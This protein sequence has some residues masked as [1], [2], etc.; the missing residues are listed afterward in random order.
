MAAYTE[1]PIIFALSNPRAQPDANPAGLIAWADGRVLIASCSPFPPA[2]LSGVTYVV[3]QVNNDKLYSG[4][5]PGVTVSRASRIGDGMLGSA[6]VESADVEGQANSGLPASSSRCKMQSGSGSIDGSRRPAGEYEALL[7]REEIDLLMML[8]S[9][10]L[11]H[12]S[13]DYRRESRVPRTPSRL[14]AAIGSIR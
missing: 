4:L 12:V 9:E 1:R 14:S 2:T 8:T 3:A 6:A 5:G 13:I 11:R 10:E 7:L